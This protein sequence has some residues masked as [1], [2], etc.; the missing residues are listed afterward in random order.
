VR[1]S[2]RSFTVG[3]WLVEPERDRITRGSRSSYLRH[4]VMELL[5]YLARHAERVV[6]AEELLADLW[7][8]K[9]V[10]TGTVY[11]CVAELR[12]ALADGEDPPGKYI[13]T[14]PKKGYRLLAPVTG[15]GDS[16]DPAG[17]SGDTP[18]SP[19]LPWGRRRNT[20]LGIVMV[21]AAI[22]GGW[23]AVHLVA[24]DR[25]G[26]A[27]MER[28]VQRFTID[29]PSNIRD[30]RNPY[31]PVTVTP[32][33][34]R[35]IF[36][37]SLEGKS[38]LFSRAIDSLIAEPIRGSE[39]V[40]I[41]ALSPDGE[42]IVFFDFGDGLLKKIPVA[43][44]VPVILCDRC[45]VGAVDDVAWGANGDIVLVTAKH[46]GLLRV[47]SSGGL[48]EELTAPGPDETHKQPEFSGDGDILF[49][50]VGER[51]GTMRKSDRVAALSLI[52]GEEKVL[53]A[54]ASAL[55]LSD[56]HLLYFAQGTLWAVGFD[57]GRLAV[58]SEPVAVAEDVDYDYE[59]RYSVSK[60]GTLVYLMT[61]DYVARRLVWVDRFG[62]EEPVGIE[63]RPY[64]LPRISPDGQSIA[65]V[66]EAR[67]G[68]DLWMFSIDRGTSSRLTF[69]E[70]RETNPVWSPDG[71]YVY[72]SSN[73][74]DNLFRVAT[75]GAH[76]IEQLTS[77]PNYQFPSGISPDGSILFFDSDQGSDINFDV[78]VLKLSA[79]PTPEPLLHSEF[80]EF[81]AV[82]SRDGQWLAYASNVSGNVEIYLRPYPD[83]EAGRWQVSVGGLSVLAVF[84]PVVWDRS[85]K[86]LFYAGASQMMSV[87]IETAP[88]VKIGTPEPMFDL[89]TY[90]IHE[91]NFGFDWDPQRERFLMVKRPPDH[92][93][94]VNRIVIVQNWLDSIAARL[95]RP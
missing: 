71:R 38:S 19:S 78:S 34:R 26:D 36:Q 46:A 5:V 91:G 12:Q 30:S 88:E 52:T 41:Y 45:G 13:E 83:I 10:T 77:S 31:S 73:R 75:T 50:T 47:S 14:L 49:F 28:P 67:E 68:A 94:P 8:G 9:I 82:P 22:A 54:G 21:V 7:T 92:E 32:D 42:W 84:N 33:G 15:L 90:M 79:E 70:S 27:L 39:R 55:M 2:E 3:G 11:N 40:A 25:S 1:T 56:R 18:A 4:Q 57:V 81:G 53:M 87:D 85:G 37:A 60:D 65:V 62:D 35:V 72:Y 58:T 66:V 95:D 76:S 63:R 20:V 61:T 89:R 64:Y 44:G 51:G 93:L 43:G 24:A 69:D 17:K 29:L 6:S 23:L 86:R 59:A 48:V 80:H 74:I 16:A